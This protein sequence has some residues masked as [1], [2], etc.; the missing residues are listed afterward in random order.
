MEYT[1][2]LTTRDSHQ[3]ICRD[4]SSILIQSELYIHKII[5]V[6][7]FK[8]INQSQSLPNNFHPSDTYLPPQFGPY[9]SPH[10]PSQQHPA[11]LTPSATIARE[12]S[13]LKGPGMKPKVSNIVTLST[14]SAAPPGQGHMPSHHLAHYESLKQAAGSSPHHPPPTYANAENQETP[15]EFS[16]LVSYFSS[17]HDDLE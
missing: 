14:A 12:E 10:H 9:V 11:A 3:P 4:P 17:Q 15:G 6:C 2:D 7:T 13:N 8:I 16:G 5:Q 1:E